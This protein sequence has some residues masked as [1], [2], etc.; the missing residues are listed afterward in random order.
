MTSKCYVCDQQAVW[1]LDRA[2]DAQPS[3]YRCTCKCHE[4]TK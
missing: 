3:T 4:V 1:K 2:A